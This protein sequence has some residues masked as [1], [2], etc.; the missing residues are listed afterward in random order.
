[1]TREVAVPDCGTP[2]SVPMAIDSFILGPLTAY[3]G[4]FPCDIINGTTLK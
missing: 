1:V 4:G 3:G 2:S